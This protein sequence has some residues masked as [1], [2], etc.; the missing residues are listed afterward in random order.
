[1]GTGMAGNGEV[2]AFDSQQI[3]V[4]AR[5]IDDACDLLEGGVKTLVDTLNQ[6]DRERSYY[7][8]GSDSP[9]YGDDDLGRS[10][11]D[12]GDGKSSF[13][14]FRGARD[15]LLGGV[16]ELAQTLRDHVHGAK[17]MAHIYAQAEHASDVSAVFTPTFPM[18][19]DRESVAKRRAALKDLVGAPAVDGLSEEATRWDLQWVYELFEFM[20]AGCT[21]PRG[22]EHTYG[23]VA[24]ALDRMAE[25]IDEVT[26]VSTRHVKDIAAE[27]FGKAIDAFVESFETLTRG[28]GSLVDAADAYRG[29]A[30]YCRYFGA[31][32][33][34]AKQAFK[35]AAVYTAAL[36]QLVKLLPTLFPSA[37]LIALAETKQIGLTLRVMLTGVRARAVAVGVAL[38]GGQ[39]AIGQLAR[40][41]NGLPTDWAAISKAAAFG[42]L[43]GLT[44]TST[45]LALV[46]AGENSGLAAFLAH[47]VPGQLAVNTGVGFGLNVAGDAVFNHGHVDWVKDLGTAAGMAGIMSYSHIFSRTIDTAHAERLQGLSEQ[48]FGPDVARDITTLAG[49]D[50]VNR[51]DALVRVLAEENGK[52]GHLPDPETFRG[53]TRSALGLSGGRRV[54]A[55][56]VD[57]LTRTLAYYNESGKGLPP[58]VRAL[59]EFAKTSV[60][61]LAGR[62]GGD[63]VRELGGLLRFHNAWRPGEPFDYVR[64][65]REEVQV[66]QLAYD[67]LAG[68]GAGRDIEITERH[69]DALLTKLFGPQQTEV[70]GDGASHLD[71]R[72]TD[73][74]IL[75]GAL[76]GL[77]PGERQHASASLVDIHQVIRKYWDVPPGQ[78][79]TVEDAKALARLWPTYPGEALDPKEAMGEIAQGLLRLDRP[80]TP[81]EVKSAG[82]TLSLAIDLVGEDW[83]AVAE[84]FRPTERITD[85]VRA[86]Y[87]IPLDE[88]V[89]AE[90]VRRYSD[91]LMS[92]HGV[93]RDRASTPGSRVLMDAALVSDF[94]RLDLEARNPVEHRLMIGEVVRLHELIRRE[95]PGHET[96]SGR[97]S[98]RVFEPVAEKLTGDPDPYKKLK[99]Y[100]KVRTDSADGLV[101]SIRDLAKSSHAQK[102]AF[103]KWSEFDPIEYTRRNYVGERVPAHWKLPEGV[104][105]GHWVPGH[106]KQRIFDEDIKLIDA[107]YKIFKKMGIRPGQFNSILDIGSGA[108]LYPAAAVVPFL[109]P[110]GRVTRLVYENNLQEIEWNKVMLDLD[111]DGICRGVDRD[112]VPQELDT[113]GIWR[114]WESVFRGHGAEYFPDR[115]EQFVDADIKAL[116]RS[117]AVTGDVFKLPEELRAELHIE[118]FAGDSFT[119]SIEES[120]AFRR[121]IIDSVR[122]GG[123]VVIGNVLNNPKTAG[124]GAGQ[125]YTAGDGTLFPN[126]AY[127]RSKWEEFLTRLSGVESY[128]I[129]ETRGEGPGFSAGE[130]GL[131]LVVIKMKE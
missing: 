72:R 90:L 35:A 51:M 9:W 65:A 91:E 125:G 83:P 110:G 48:A 18:S 103:S 52:P 105:P 100:R 95:W 78:I 67:L 54:T 55:Y 16:A 37:T 99:L 8:D 84:Y 73:L 89:S 120:F 85:L 62:A 1:M 59:H 116:E 127:Y 6:L 126:T 74:S 25:V 101:N 130:D 80:P 64:H 119:T 79:P 34:S 41:R 107:L 87:G 118:F 63:A 47:G 24:G 123:V 106:F 15:D 112:G 94:Y 66:R 117:E 71:P 14:G 68:E 70:A 44:F 129:Y 97:G 4:S 30:A 56:E 11:F 32:I 102:G 46:K 21:Y 23:Q 111:G 26:H 69:V 81:E 5:K 76:D 36:W 13:S 17:K 96:L 29:L 27:N 121:Q 12:G 2:L 88:H 49:A 33:K 61:E 43:G 45:H 10:F 93:G 53:W 113:R 104:D 3:V 92:E 19:E 38:T 86:E 82:R 42:G 128:E 131:G 58:G 109:A 50:H 57:S 122:R 28:R 20:V 75:L 115:A 98:F 124:S 39:S 22:D 31:E 114:P 77:P 40:A 7:F 108:N 60:P